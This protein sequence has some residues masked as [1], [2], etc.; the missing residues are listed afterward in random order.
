M[1]TY[2]TQKEGVKMIEKNKKIYSVQLYALPKN[3]IYYYTKF[4]RKTQKNIIKEFVK[5]NEI[6]PTQKI[7]V[8]KTGDKKFL[9]E[10]IS[11]TLISTYNITDYTWIDKYGHIKHSQEHESVNETTF[12]II[13]NEEI[14]QEFNILKGSRLI[15]KK[16][17]LKEAS[18]NE[19]QNYIQLNKN[20]Q[21]MLKKLETLY[22]YGDD[23]YEQIIFKPKRKI[24]EKK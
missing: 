19:I 6:Q 21:T 23:N 14:Y 2:L 15:E 17:S 13:H 3:V 1:I 11:D 12:A 5:E 7:L 18:I 22:D 9:R 24:K 8:Q 4:E 10:I 16:S 20:K